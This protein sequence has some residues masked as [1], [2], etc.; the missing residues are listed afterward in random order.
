LPDDASA[1]FRIKAD[2]PDQLEWMLQFA[3]LAPAIR[4]AECIGSAGSPPFHALEQAFEAIAIETWSSTPISSSSLS[5]MLSSSRPPVL[6]G[7]HPPPGRAKPIR[8]D[9]CERDRSQYRSV[10]PRQTLFPHPN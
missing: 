6:A 3:S 4:D 8:Q 5:L 2:S 10:E 1:Y 7:C 9:G